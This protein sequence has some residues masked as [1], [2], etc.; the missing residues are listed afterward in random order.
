MFNIS[1]RAHFN[2]SNNSND[3][4]NNLNDEN[5][6][7]GLINK[8]KAFI[9]NIKSG[10]PV[11]IYN[12]A[13]KTSRL[14][15]TPECVEWDFNLNFVS[16]D[17]NSNKESA[18]YYLLISKEKFNFYSGLAE[19]LS[20]HVK[21]FLNTGY[22]KS[23]LYLLKQNPEAL[24]DFQYE[25]ADHL[26]ALLLIIVKR[27]ELT[28]ELIVSVKKY[29][30]LKEFKQE[31]FDR[32]IF[33]ISSDEINHYCL[34]QAHLACQVTEVARTNLRLTAK[35]VNAKFLI[36]RDE[37]NLKEH[38]AIIIGNEAEFKNPI[39][40][41]HSSCYT[42]D[43]LASLSCDCR[44]QLHLAIKYISQDSEGGVLIY[45]TQEGRGI[46]LVNKIKAYN[47]QAHNS[48]DTVEANLALGFNADERDLSVG[49]FILKKLGINT[50]R[51]ITNNPEKLE[52]LRNNGINITDR[53]KLNL[54]EN[55]YNSKYIQT[56]FEKL[57]HLL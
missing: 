4:T 13:D 9:L 42:G 10:L 39:I 38:Y 40:R 27:F 49:A 22:E 3:N 6:I 50:A 11:I 48:L 21:I 51:I 1:G 53:I 24:S 23:S 46:G 45:L 29:N 16:P 55:S 8:V 43:L 35:C 17:C 34:A 54:S 15:F 30:N 47:L 41:I 37:N 14:I 36:Y 31:A 32:G 12:Q 57:G 26:E 28:P 19:K 44:D 20:A 2:N 33:I 25:E 7:K 18:V 52:V 5:Y 56:K